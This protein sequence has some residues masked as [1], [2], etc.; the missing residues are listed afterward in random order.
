MRPK[1]AHEVDKRADP[2]L[3]AHPGRTHA[4]RRRGLVRLWPLLVPPSPNKQPLS[5]RLP[6]IQSQT[7]LGVFLAAMFLRGNG[8]GSAIKG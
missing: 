2:A 1:A 7:S 4:A 5:V 3:A 6:S 8:L